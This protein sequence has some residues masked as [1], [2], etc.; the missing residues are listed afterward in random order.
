MKTIRGLS[1]ALI[2]LA[3]VTSN[4]ANATDYQ[5]GR[6][7]GEQGYVANNVAYHEKTFVEYVRW[8][9]SMCVYSVP[10]YGPEW[11][12]EY[13]TL[14]GYMYQ[15]GP[16]GGGMVRACTEREWYSY[17]MEMVGTKNITAPCGY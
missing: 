7:Y 16:S 17:T 6:Y 1:L 9:P 15:Y 2:A 14:C 3:T 12:S 11:H 13:A 5:V 10:V 4:A 8:Q